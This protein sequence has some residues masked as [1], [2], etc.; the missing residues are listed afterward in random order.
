MKSTELDEETAENLQDLMEQDY[1]L[2]P[3]TVSWF[4]R[5]ACQL[6]DLK[7]VDEGEFHEW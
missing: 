5:E 2:V 1:A 7:D 3:N 6:D 4:T